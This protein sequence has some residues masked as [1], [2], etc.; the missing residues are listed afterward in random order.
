MGLS[1]PRFGW[2]ALAL[3]LFACAGGGPAVGSRPSS[4]PNTPVTLLPP[5]A[6]TDDFSWRQRVTVQYG[7]NAARSFDAVLQKKGAVLSLVGLTPINTVT[8][9]VRQEGTNVTFDNRTGQSLPFDGRHILQDVQR[10][11]FPWLTED[12]VDGTRT[13]VVLGETVTERLRSGRVVERV[14]DRDGLPSV[15]VALNPADR[16]G[17][18]PAPTA[19]LTNDRYGYRLVI[20]TSPE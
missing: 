5:S 9:L 14:F 19:V 10:V 6:M 13:G 16:P 18:G 7:D 1:V 17:S 2:G 3:L 20:A 11:F 12:V 8:F 15:R 4:R